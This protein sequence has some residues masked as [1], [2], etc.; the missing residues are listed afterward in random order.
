MSIMQLRVAHELRILDRG[1]SNQNMYRRYLPAL[2]LIVLTVAVFLQVRDHG[3]VWDDRVNVKENPH[4]NPATPAS[5]LQ[6]WEKPYESL[7]VPLTYSVWA[8]I[9]PFASLPIMTEE[10]GQNLD[11]QL[12]H[13]ANLVLHLLSV[14]VVLAILRMLVYNEW[15]AFCGALLFALHP[16]QVEPVAWVTGMKDLLSG[17]FSLI[18][19]W[20]YLGYAVAAPDADKKQT[21]RRDK[22]SAGTS[23]ASKVKGLHYSIA[24]LAFV[25]ALLAKPAAI[26]VPL[27][28]GVLD[29]WLIRR[30]VRYSL[31][32]LGCWALVGMPF[33]VLTKWAQPDA[34]I[35]FI[36]PLWAR[37]LVAG[38]AAAFYLYKLVVPL[39]L[40]PD[41]G[42]S[43]A[44]LL[45]EGWIYFTWIVPVG[46]GVFVWLWRKRMPWLF[47]SA[48]IFVVSILPVSGLIPF[49]FQDIS[50]VADRYLY[51][52]MLGPAL[53][54]AYF[55]SQNWGRLLVAACVLILGFFGIVSALQAGYWRDNISL[56]NHALKIN[57]NSWLAHFNLGVGLARQGKTEDAIGHLRETLRIKPDYADAHY[58]LGNSLAER[59][60]LDEATQHYKE[61]VR[62]EP[63]FVE[64]HFN[65]GNILLMRGEFKEAV[66]HFRQALELR[67]A[68][69]EIHVVH[70]NLGNA[71]VREG[72]LEEGIK[73]FQEAVKIKS[74]FAEAYH[75]LGR[76][77]AAQ[78]E[79]DKAIEHFR[80][81]LRIQP[82]FA[83]AHESLARALAEQGKKDEAVQHYQEAL[84]I[85]KSGRER[86]V[87]Q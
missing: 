49:G 25:L 54:L 76:I 69:S 45:R 71:L 6:F 42:R 32:A 53:A 16:L 14:L 78:G 1:Y 7:Y 80:Q 19:T 58:T 60:R 52:A 40:G 4:L 59:G 85:M 39:W 24:T 84:R 36:T 35:G 18:A 28:A 50:T 74:D 30:S 9:A 10:G 5:V 61:A 63:D 26:V 20:Q 86:T 46:L 44:S 43:P 27:I 23:D 38:D 41:Y 21:G 15:A 34:S 64:A 81:A 70:F 8:S 72:R 56:F 66:R 57:S 62:I 13:V 47:A 79:L 2:L 83:E 65:L 22:T 48:G 73:H 51:V 82:E 29:Y 12:F 77:V 87:S 11:P 33:I 68:G 67:P 31:V 55:L 37:P 75:S 17:F 3:F